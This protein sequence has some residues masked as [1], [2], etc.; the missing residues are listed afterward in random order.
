MPTWIIKSVTQTGQNR[1]KQDVLIYKNG[2]IIEFHDIEKYDQSCD[3]FIESIKR[4]KLPQEV[5]KSSNYAGSDFDYCF[6][7]RQEELGTSLPWRNYESSEVKLEKY[8]PEWPKLYQQ[9]YNNILDAYRNDWTLIG[10][11]LLLDMEHIG[12]TSVEGMCAKPII[13]M[14]IIGQDGLRG[15]P[16]KIII[17][18]ERMGYVHQYPYITH[19]FSEFAEFAHRP[20]CV[21]MPPRGKG[22]IMIKEGFIVQIVGRIE[23]FIAF[24]EYLRTHPV[25]R[26][27]YSEAKERSLSYSS[28]TDCYT[29]NKNAILND[30]LDKAVQWYRQLKNYTHI[31]IFDEARKRWTCCKA[32]EDEYNA[33]GEIY[34]VPKENMQYGCYNLGSKKENYHPGRYFYIDYNFI[35]GWWTCCSQGLYSNGCVN[36]ILLANDDAL[37]KDYN[38]WNVDCVCRWV[39][40][41][42]NIHKDYS[43]NFRQHNING[44]LLLTA[45]DDAVL[46]DL[47]ISSVLHRK[48]FL[49]AI[50]ELKD[51][52]LSNSNSGAGLL[53]KNNEVKKVYYDQFEGDFAPLLA[54]HEMTN[55]I[56]P[57][58]PNVSSC[59]LTNEKHRSIV[60]RIYNWLGALPSHFQV[61]T[62]EYVFNSGRYRMFL[63]QLESVENRQ[64][65]P[66]FQP[67]LNDENSCEERKRVLQRLETLYQCVSHNRSA[68]IVRMWHGCRRSILPNLLSDGFAALGTLDDG[69]YGKAMYFTSSAK[70]ATRYCSETAGCLIMCYIVL[71]N[72]F[73][74]V[75]AD[76]SLDI[77]PNQFRFYGKGNYRNYQCHYVPVSPVGG[78]NTWNYRPPPNGIDDAVYDELAVFQE[79]SI[80]PQIVVHFK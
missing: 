41:L 3:S 72:P 71:L 11:R 66:P 78:P 26:D 9:E 7:D 70:Y 73:P 25:A 5:L 49:K 46:Q 47:G 6:E 2:F 44:Q 64:K 56:A 18:L 17:T 34:S 19:C 48:L 62:I 31:G 32:S 8:N 68:R 23:N 77:S 22:T 58:Y 40:S 28:R 21:K 50:E 45:V 69:W 10:A 55:S 57:L 24:R 16:S 14:L 36:V 54:S 13:D 30:L 42:M 61:D 35:K 37:L 38:N 29:H 1:E 59:Q 63:G 27:E 43:E 60:S 15:G 51:L 20:D 79:A 53:L 12:S 74:V 67:K 76:A 80:L 75:T 4:K 52:L 39:R 65:Q 33:C